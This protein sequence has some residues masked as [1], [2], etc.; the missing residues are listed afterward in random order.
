MNEQPKHILTP[1]AD[2]VRTMLGYIMLMAPFMGIG[3]GLGAGF[4]ILIVTLA[5]R[6]AGWVVR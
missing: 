6:W 2:E 5:L 4:V 3:L 1:F